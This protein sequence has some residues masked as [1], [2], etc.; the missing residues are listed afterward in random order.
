MFM[1]VFGARIHFSL[2]TSIYSQLSV[3]YS[4]KD[5]LYNNYVYKT[6]EHKLTDLFIASA[7]KR[8]LSEARSRG[9]G[10]SMLSI[11]LQH[12]FCLFIA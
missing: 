7:Q 9:A 6:M 3:Y 8:A 12:F 1:F 2:A 5:Y 4:Q 10:P 11:D